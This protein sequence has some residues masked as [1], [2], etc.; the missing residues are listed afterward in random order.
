MHHLETHSDCTSDADQGELY[1]HSIAQM[2]SNALRTICY[3]QWKQQY[4]A[5][6]DRSGAS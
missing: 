6:L 5:Q 2:P 1:P 4:T 3:T